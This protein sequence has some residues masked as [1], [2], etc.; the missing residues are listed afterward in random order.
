MG[1]LT[2]QAGKTKKSLVGERKTFDNWEKSFYMNNLTAVSDINNSGNYEGYIVIQDPK[3]KL[4]N[5]DKSNV[6]IT[7][8]ATSNGIE[9]G[10]VETPFEVR[11]IKDDLALFYFV[12]H[13]G[14]QGITTRFALN[15]TK[16]PIVRT[17]TIAQLWTNYHWVLDME[18][19]FT[20]IRDVSGNVQDNYFTFH[21]APTTKYNKF[22][23]PMLHFDGI[24]D[25][26]YIGGVAPLYNEDAAIPVPFTL[27]AGI[28]FDYGHNTSTRMVYAQ[29]SS[30]SVNN[31]LHIG[32]RPNNDLVFGY[33]GNDLDYDYTPPEGAA[34][35]HIDTF[36]DGYC[37]FATDGE[38]AV[39]AGSPTNQRRIYNVVQDLTLKYVGGTH[40]F[41]NTSTNGYVGRFGINSS[42]YFI[43]SLY[44]VRMKKTEIN[45]RQW[46]TL[47]KN[48]YGQLFDLSKPF[49]GYDV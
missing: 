42:F 9:V 31:I 20:N 33:Y 18:N 36:L 49:V 16:E 24:D 14:R 23:I 28:D 40:S 8:A 13:A 5:A 4:I 39:I 26:I 12:L 25:Y 38:K 30:N 46:R 27:I 41:S 44:D 6:R 10:R 2:V 29:G 35:D 45:I 11:Y 17:T 22:G 48:Y 43:G 7:R 34:S 21:G 15:I 1:M 19:G 3:I 32:F 47:R 37:A